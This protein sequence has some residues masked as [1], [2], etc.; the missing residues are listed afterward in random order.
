MFLERNFV[1]YL[2]LPSIISETLSKNFLYKFF[3]NPRKKCPVRVRI[4]V[5]LLKLNTFDQDKDNDVT[6]DGSISCL[7]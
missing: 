2:Y 5:L 4:H 6:A 1:F 7:C 3:A